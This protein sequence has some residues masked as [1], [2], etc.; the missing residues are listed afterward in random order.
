VVDVE[1]AQAAEAE[2]LWFHGTNEVGWAAIQA[3]GVLWGNV[4]GSYRYTYLTPHKAVA[5]QYGSVLLRVRYIPKGVGS[6][7]DNYGFLADAPE[8]GM[9]CW[10]FSV[11]EPIPV[12][13]VWRA[14]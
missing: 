5:E 13:Q 4:T 2:G 1:E 9:T 3:E 11:F 6:T 10:Q 8:P 14:A 12:G 7:V